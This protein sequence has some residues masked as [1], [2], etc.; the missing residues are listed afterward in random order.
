MTGAEAC[1]FLEH[2]GVR[3]TPA[4]I[5]TVRALD[6][7]GGLMTSLQIEDALQTV[8]RSSISR[9]LSLFVRRGLVHTVDDGTGAV[10]Y[11]LCRAPHHAHGHDKDGAA[12][13]PVNDADLHPHFHCVE[14][15]RTYCINGVAIPRI[16][17]PEGFSPLTASMV[18]H[19]VCADCAG[20]DSAA[21]QH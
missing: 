9:T 12:A 10:K 11:E 5:L 21:P 13:L 16:A 19:G 4:R 14:C 2:N 20:H 3:P 15:G 6:N 7:A 8:D 17:L 1:A 18:I